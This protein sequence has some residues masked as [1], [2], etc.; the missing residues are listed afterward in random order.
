MN[1]RSSR[2]PGTSSSRQAG[3]KEAPERLWYPGRGAFSITTTDASGRGR[4]QLLL[5]PDR[6]GEAGRAPADD[7]DVDRGGHAFPSVARIRSGTTVSMSPT[8]PKSA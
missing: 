1:R 8:M 3:S 6:G 5:E 4:R 2:Q 7:Q